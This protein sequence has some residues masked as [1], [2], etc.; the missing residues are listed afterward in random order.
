[1]KI[2]LVP[3][4]ATA[5]LKDGW[6]V[7][8]NSDYNESIL[9]EGV[10]EQ[11][12]LN[13]L[14]QHF[15]LEFGDFRKQMILRSAPYLVGY[16]Y[17][18]KIVR[19]YSPR[20]NYELFLIPEVEKL[21]N[22]DQEE[23]D[24]LNLFKAHTEK[25]AELSSRSFPSVY[26]V[27]TK[28][29]ELPDLMEDEYYANLEGES[30]KKIDKLLIYLNGYSPSL[31]EKVSDW[32]LGLTA[33][34]ALLR[35]HL[36]KF[37]AI[38]PSLDH[39]TQGHEVKRILLE[40]IRRLINDSMKS[41]RLLL[42]GQ[43]KALPLSLFIWCRVAFYICK[44][45]PA[46]S[47]AS[48]VR[49]KVRFMAKRFIAGETI[50]TSQEALKSL[51]ETGRD[52]TLD[53][54]GELVV[55][56]KEADHYCNEVIK[57]IKGFSLHVKKG[58]RNAAGINRAHVSIKVS[59]LCS[60]FKPYAPEYTYEH[61][62]PRLKKILLAAKQEDVFINIDAEHYDYRDIVFKVYKRVLLETEEL[63]DYSATG[64]VLQA[65]LRD[66]HEH[67]NEIVEL[68]NER[69]IV[70]PIR[71]VKGAYWDAETVEADAH[72]FDAPEFLNKEETDLHFRQLIVKIFEA[73]KNIQLCLA[74]HNFADHCFAEALRDDRFSDIPIIEH[75]CLHMTYEAL[76][77]A[78]AKMNWVVRN[79]VPIG[80]LIVGMAYLVR[81]IMEN[82]SQVGVL[83][84]MR[85]HKKQLSLVS[86]Y[87]THREKIENGHLERDKS[88]THLTG[89][90]FNVTPLRTYLDEQRQWSESELDVFRAS[91]LGK[92][93]DNEFVKEGKKTQIVSSSNPEL[94]VG[95]I[96]F[97]T[98]DDAHR[99][100]QTVDEAY[101]SGDWAK[102]PWIRRASTLLRAA[103]F[104]LARR[105]ELSSLIV[106]E[107][108]K[109]INEALGDVDEAID[110]L[111]FYAREEFRLQE[112]NDRLESRGAIAVISP[113][114]FPLAIPCGMVVSSLVVGNTVI[115]KSAEQTPLISQILV[116]IL[117]SSGVPK[118]VLI[119]LPGDGETV[120][121]A[122]V[123]NERI[124]GIVF[125]GSKFVG[126]LIA[127]TAH[128]RI[129]ENKL[130]NMS[131]PVRI[132]TEMGGKNAVIVTAN[133]E[134]DETV[135]GILYSAFG[136]AGQK[137]SAASRVLVDNAVKDKLIERL[138][139]ACHTIE[140]G[141]AYDFK[142][143]INPV[144]TLEDKKRLISQVELATK[145]ANEFGGKVHIDRSKDDLPGYCVGPTVIELPMT[146]AINKESF[147]LRELFGPV[148]HIVGFNHLDQALRIYNASEYA[149]TGG[150]FSQSQDDIDY[151][152]SKMESGNI[153][154]NRTI[155]GARVGIEPF[156]GFKLSGTGPNA[157]GKA[158]LSYLHLNPA[159]DFKREDSKTELGSEYSFDLSR[160]S[161]LS[162]KGRVQ[163]IDKVLS[164]FT[165][166]FEHLFRGIRGEEKIVLT[167]FHKWIVNNFEEYMAK[168]HWNKKIPG[169]LSYDDYKLSSGKTVIVSFNTA[170]DFEI[171]IHSMAAIACGSGV[172]VLCRNNAAYDWWMGI[173]DV[174]VEYGFSKENFEVYFVT[175]QLLED[176]LKIGDIKNVLLDGSVDDLAQVIEASYLAS[177]KH[178]VMRSF[179][180]KYDSSDIYDF[181]RICRQFIN[182]RSFAV[183]TMRHGAPMD[184]IL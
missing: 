17:E 27:I 1:M 126:T 45:F 32:G 76:S 88:Q 174:L 96:N 135:S 39:D 86:P 2:T 100:V 82:S 152:T 175:N 84:I 22:L 182:I 109:S 104:M 141:V 9:N 25:V 87:D 122:L 33:Q 163:R 38:L 3:S 154:V 170:I 121:D 173:R 158:Y 10:V 131:Y 178:T 179:S 140:V 99:A 98:I 71:L 166:H 183:N 58:D 15:K 21:T 168:E 113:W 137:C 169:Q 59:A 69:G 31:F 177:D 119:H 149:L 52:V 67:L 74:S 11:S 93:Y 160:D 181:K 28:S 19:L 42:K 176:T 107:A 123:K 143:T 50:E 161:G 64:I 36:L 66:A 165:R 164:H 184:V 79:Y 18:D 116:D 73:S 90:F 55:S 108:G 110:F 44:F 72:S 46:K 134:L 106:Y 180:S 155:T 53:Q 114:N 172:T 20:L 43:N 81:R 4:L 30:A 40:A 162:S 92:F 136:H 97:A 115:L 127:K 78:M 151:L 83:T 54:L 6:K 147:A 130:L 146:R 47:L 62:A 117:H 85:S 101:N 41:K 26:Q 171:V 139:E 51:F 23:L 37:L 112:H 118:D 57:L 142:T 61:V 128:K 144:I 8:Y 24:T 102:A 138:K 95:E 35:I 125:T 65:Y 129:Y 5:E 167:K 132:I 150:V 156:G 89:K 75:Q 12:V 94:L 13:E 105:N 68:A 16:F 120:G 153:Y 103:N 63:K 145:E 124:A 48:I 157:G 111:T 77:T 60:D 148:V 91:S 7:I 34:Y 133:A 14:S 159:R 56:E 49:F 29:S 80:S 70:M